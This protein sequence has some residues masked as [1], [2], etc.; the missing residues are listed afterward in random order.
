MYADLGS[1]DG[2]LYLDRILM[3]GSTGSQL[4]AVGEALCRLLAPLRWQHVYVPLLPYHLT[5]L[6]QAPT[7]YL[8][9]VQKEVCMYIA[10]IALDTL[11]HLLLRTVNTGRQ[12]VKTYVHLAASPTS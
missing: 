9:G 11:L 10:Q 6:L 3:L 5:E 4:V 7:P 2:F 1:A 12:Q 8:M